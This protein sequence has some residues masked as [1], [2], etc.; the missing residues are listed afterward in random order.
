VVMMGLAS[1]SRPAP[2][3]AVAAPS[4]SESAPAIAPSAE[5]GSGSGSGSGSDANAP[6]VVD[7]SA[8]DAAVPPKLRVYNI[9]MH[10]GGGPNDDE[11]KA[12]IH[13]SVEPHFPEIAACFPPSA[14]LPV[15]F[16]VDLVID[17][18][19]GKAQVARP[20]TKLADDAFIACVV[21]VFASID[22][23]PPRFGKTVVRYS[24]RYD[25][26]KGK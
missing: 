3:T 11:T 17:A 19:G 5:A 23:L 8:I 6:P 10:I 1:C 24:L 25:R 22:F 2:P 12:P 18:K 16:G 20:R 4:A 15:D 13:K 9:G 21:G 26:L 7:A 14:A